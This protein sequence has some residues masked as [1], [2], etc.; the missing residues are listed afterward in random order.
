MA[1]TD[2]TKH[3][4]KPVL[5]EEPGAISSPTLNGAGLKIAIV[6]TRQSQEIVEVLETSCRGELLLKGV[7]RE[8]ICNVHVSVP[9]EL[10]Y[11]VARELKSAPLDAVVCIGCVVKGQ[12][13]SFDFVSEAVTRALMK[14][15]LK[16]KVPV[17]NGVLTCVDMAQAR[18]AAGLVDP[19][20]RECNHGVEW[21]QSAIEMAHFNRSMKAKT[22]KEC[23]CG[24]HC[25]TKGCGCTCHCTQ[26]AKGQCAAAGQCADPN[27]SCEKKTTTTTTI[28]HA[29]EISSAFD[30]LKVSG[31]AVCKP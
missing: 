6:T 15:G 11:A 30:E 16:K 14:I 25:G 1:T 28:E 19:K 26:C 2:R 9:F 5:V 22:S 8:N 27:C 29:S 12:T 13:P 10:P 18:A 24:C 4:A 17:I 23:V 20:L 3:V 7:T 21:A 31:G